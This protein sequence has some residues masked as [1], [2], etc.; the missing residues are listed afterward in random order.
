MP[1]GRIDDA[2]LFTPLR[3]ALLTV[4]DA[5]ELSNDSAGDLLAQR[6]GAAGHALAARALLNHDKAAIEAKAR[7]WIDDA[8]I[9]VI[10][11]NGGTGMGD[12]DL[13][14]ELWRPH[15][16]QEFEGFATLW[17][18]VAYETVGVSTLQSRACAG[19]AKGTVIYVL[20]GSTGACADGWD[21]IIGLQLDSR[22]RP[23][24]AVELIRRFRKR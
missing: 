13:L 5:R 23:N 2:R 3:I 8:G 9:D 21:K 15:F 20:P 11:S 24:S 1:G 19:I 22:H 12:R 16:E 10:I 7:T 4:S 17:H 14:P 6:L 18:L